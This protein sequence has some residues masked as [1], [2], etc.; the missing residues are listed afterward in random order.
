MSGSSSIP[1]EGQAATLEYT[2]TVLGELDLPLKYQ[3]DVFG[4]PEYRE[5]GLESVWA[6]TLKTVMDY[7]IKVGEMEFVTASD[8]TWYA[9]GV[10]RVRR[11]ATERRPADGGRIITRE[12]FVGID[13]REVEQ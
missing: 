1:F 7:S 4:G 13:L 6:N 12:H 5:I 2:V 10:G 9:P 8:T 11:E 3:T